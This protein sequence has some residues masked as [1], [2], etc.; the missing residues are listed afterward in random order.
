M[1]NAGRLCSMN[2][3]MIEQLSLRTQTSLDGYKLFRHLLPSF[4]EFFE[5]NLSKEVR[6]DSLVIRHAATAQA[7]G[8]PPDS[9]DVEKLLHAARKIDREFT[10]QITPLP[11]RID[12]QYDDIEPVR[13]TRFRLLLD[14]SY[15]LFVQLEITPGFRVAVREI[16]SGEEFRIL[17]CYMLHLYTVETRLLNR[18]VV[19]PLP[20]HPLKDAMTSAINSVMEREAVQLG[21]EITRR[22]YAGHDASGH[23]LRP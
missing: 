18:S 14:E 11:I 4:S 10:R 19:I 9:G 20:L 6:K 12:I 21:E 8:T 3:S 23:S 13:K 22:V 2:R 17:I 5:L 1:N 15:R 7:L 16:Y